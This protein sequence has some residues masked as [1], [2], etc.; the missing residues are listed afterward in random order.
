[1]RT[2]YDDGF[3]PEEIR[4]TLHILGFK[5]NAPTEEDHQRWIA[6]MEN[7]PRLPECIA[8]G[9]HSQW[10]GTCPKCENHYN[11]QKTKSGEVVIHE[12]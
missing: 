1:M 2:M 3:S 8:K 6:E 5:P 12:T 4:S 7:A 11:V 9:E 10:E